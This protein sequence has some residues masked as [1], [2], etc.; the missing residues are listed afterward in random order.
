MSIKTEV[1]GFDISKNSAAVIGCGGLGTNVATHLAGA[2]IGK[3][4]L[5]DFDSV[6]KRNLNR[7][8]FYTEAD[9]G[10]PKCELL[11]K[12]LAA[13]APD[14]KVSCLYRRI[15]GVT[16]ADGYDIIIIAVD[17][18]ETRKNV[19]R[20]CTQH[21]TPCI[22]GSINGFFG[23][24]YMYIPDTTPDLEEA[25]CLNE[26][27]VKNQ[28]PSVTAGIIGTL[29]AKLAIDYFLGNTDNAGRLYIFDNNEIHSLKVRSDNLDR[30]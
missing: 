10:K 5:V 22:N 4:L 3:L 7:Q 21:K 13:Y 20:Y 30:V 15:D 27:G 12:R 8:F 19:S 1:Q 29:E 28:S 2:G 14:C 11:A 18:I 25:G 24:A 17:N 16:F 9:I 23:T 26:T 6:E